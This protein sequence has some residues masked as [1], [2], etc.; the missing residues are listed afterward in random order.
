MTVNR[1]PVPLTLDIAQGI[2][3][4]FIGLILGALLVAPLVG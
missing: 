4:V 3:V 2:A 1:K